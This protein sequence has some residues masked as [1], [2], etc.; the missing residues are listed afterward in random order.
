MLLCRC[1]VYKSLAAV[2]ACSVNSLW[3]ASVLDEIFR[4]RFGGRGGEGRF[5]FENK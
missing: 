1:F 2:L 5:F 4:K 3:L